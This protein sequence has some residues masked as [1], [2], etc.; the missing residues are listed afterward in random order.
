MEDYCMYPKK[1]K[2]FE[3]FSKLEQE[4]YLFYLPILKERLNKIHNIDETELFWERVLGLTLLI[5]I[6]QCL[7]V[8]KSLK[9]GDKGKK[10]F[11]NVRNIKK[12]SIPWDEKEYRDVFINSS[13][14]QSILKKLFYTKCIE[15]QYAQSVRRP[16]INQSEH[17]T[18]YDKI[19]SQN[20]FI[21]L[22]EVAII[23]IQKVVSPVTIIIEAY[24]SIRKQQEIQIVSKGNVQFK[25]INFDDHLVQV[26]INTKNRE[27]LSELSGV[28][29]DFDKY[30]FSTLKY[31]VPTSL[32]ERF[33]IRKNKAESMLSKYPMLQNIFNESMSPDALLLLALSEREK[34]NS[35]YIEHNYLQ[36]QF[37]GNNIWS[38]KRKFD[39]FLSLG[40]E[41]KSSP[42]HVPSS[43]N[44][45]W[46]I[47]SIK[48]NKN[49]EI[50]YIS[51]VAQKYF[52][53]FSSGYG[54]SGERNANN[55]IDMKKKFLN[56]LHNKIIKKFYYKNYF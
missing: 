54:Q 16:A 21:L 1:H 5:H 25:K 15:K 6:A 40:W 9:I 39:Y 17:K 13:T 51:G 23:I 12:Y 3:A 38:T 41:D 35:Y 18:L 47:E 45:N 20:L 24:W 26:Y 48:N 33:S 22:K 44:Y 14:G 34:I 10:A 29:D 36:Y 4:K 32:I 28:S 30:F 7:F 43:S 2:E 56:S 8:F 27:V 46:K 53:H 11:L 49:I 37:I 42:N 31:V 50:L 19:L 52:P 55:Y